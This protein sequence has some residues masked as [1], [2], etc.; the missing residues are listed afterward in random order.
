MNIPSLP[1]PQQPTR[2]DPLQPLL[3]DPLQL[4]LPEPLEWPGLAEKNI[5]ADILRL[6]KLHPVISGNKWFKL[7]G[8][9]QE[10]L[11]SAGHTMITFGGAWSNHLI[12]AACAARQH[13]L[14]AVG[15][16]RGE[17]PPVLS[18]TLTAAA[19]YGMQL[20][21]IPRGEYAKKETPDFL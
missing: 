6:D 19:A 21:F 12:A 5:S 15:I 8:Y 13:G 7:K 17:R 14:H 2:P 3:P 4:P 10:A 20:E 18:V 16:V 1:E 11:Q 9:L